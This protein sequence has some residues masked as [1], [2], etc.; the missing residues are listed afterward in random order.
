[1]LGRQRHNIA[2]AELVLKKENDEDVGGMHIC[3]LRLRLHGAGDVRIL[4]RGAGA[5]EAVTGMILFADGG[6]VSS[7][8]YAAGGNYISRMSNYCD[9]CF[10]NVS[11][12]NGAAPVH[13][14]TCTGTF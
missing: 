12:K 13:S 11:P 1:M 10:Y 2:H 8:P 14:I 7:K 3:S 9:N 4:A 5:G 6:V